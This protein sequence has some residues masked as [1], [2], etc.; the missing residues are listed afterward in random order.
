MVPHYRTERS[1]PDISIWVWERKH[2]STLRIHVIALINRIKT[3]AG[4]S[5]NIGKAGIGTDTPRCCGGI[6]GGGGY[7]GSAWSKFTLWYLKLI[8]IPESIAYLPWE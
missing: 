2:Y 3:L 4:S 6:E 8:E 1:S 5:I 7:D